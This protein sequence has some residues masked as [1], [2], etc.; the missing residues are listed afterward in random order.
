MTTIQEKQYPT[1][2][3]TIHYWVNAFKKGRATLVM[4]PGLT[5]DHRLFD[6]Q[7]EAFESKYNLLVWD[8]PGHNAS[9]PFELRFSLEDKARWLHDILTAEGIEKP[10]LIGQSM[11]GYVSQMYIHLYPEEVTGFISIGSAPLQREYYTGIELWL[12]K[13]IY[14]VYR[15]YPWKALVRDGSRG[16]ATSDYG[17]NLMREMMLTYEGAFE[18][19][20]R[21]TSHGFKMLAEAVE[22]N[23]AYEIDCP[24]LLICGERDMAGSAKSYNKRWASKTGFQLEWIPG[25]GH[26]TNTD[27]PELVNALIEKF[28]KG[29]GKD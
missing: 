10:V 3:G 29:D 19:Y 20:C 2:Y 12:L 4:L 1:K 25:A 16:C 24:A 13:H 21:L 15:M 23:L 11:G 22:Q 5:A 18:E 6:K 28:V 7:V 26:N 8:A 27:K 17:R 9:R 14:P